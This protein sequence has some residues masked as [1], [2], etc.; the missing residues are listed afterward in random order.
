M[1]EANEVLK[2]LVTCIRDAENDPL[3][4]LNQGV[5]EACI[6][7]QLLRAETLLSYTLCQHGWEDLH[8]TDELYEY[9]CYKCGERK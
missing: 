1:D 5:H 6:E 3:Y 4:S 2:A 7:K 8:G 9:W